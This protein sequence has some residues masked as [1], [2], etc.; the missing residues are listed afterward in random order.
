[1]P[2]A[3][4]QEI[5]ALTKSKAP[6]A[7]L[8]HSDSLALPR[9]TAQ[10]HPLQVP[11]RHRCHHRHRCPPDRPRWLEDVA[12]TGKRQLR[13][14]EERATYR[15]AQNVV[16]TVHGVNQAGDMPRQDH[17]RL[18]S[19]GGMAGASVAPGFAEMALDARG[20]GALKHAQLV[21]V[22]GRGQDTT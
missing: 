1:M 8:S 18:R 2:R 12:T 20:P 5:T 11:H 13:A 15:L 3:R 9:I 17:D 22:L 19:G 7:H 21:E 14:G 10:L 6:E 16:D 4:N